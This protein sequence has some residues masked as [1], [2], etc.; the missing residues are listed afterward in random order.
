M[1]CV[2]FTGEMP[3]DWSL[4]QHWNL[5][6]LL[7]LTAAHWTCTIISLEGFVRNP[8]IFR[9]VA[10]LQLLRKTLQSPVVL[11]ATLIVTFWFAEV[12][13][14]FAARKRLW[15]QVNESRFSIGTL[16]CRLQT[17]ILPAL[18]HYFAG[19]RPL[20]C[21]HWWRNRSRPNFLLAS[22]ESTNP[23]RELK[24]LKKNGGCQPCSSHTS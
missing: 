7:H 20:S 16:F 19:Y 1:L 15:G 11:R 9:S 2:V 6:T 18:V 23:Q 22:R 24:A 3:D 21:Q 14:W 10:V 13:G 5:C 17:I 12:L 4:I 8:P